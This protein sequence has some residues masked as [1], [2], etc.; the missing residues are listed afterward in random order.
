MKD[1]VIPGHEVSITVVEAG[2]KWK[3]QYKPGDRFIV[4]ADV[5]Y[6]GVNLA[7]GYALPGGMQQ[8]GIIGEPVLNGDEG[9]YLIPVKPNTGY[10]E[11]ALVE[12]WT[13][14]VAAYR[15]HP[16]R[17]VKPDGIMLIVGIE[18]GNYEIDG[19]LCANGAPKKIILPAFLKS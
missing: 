7:Y 5:Y 13:C 6:K 8:Y 18:E 15:I 17:A 12:P 2:D 10:A 14:V 9:S 1:P 4:Q 11:A 16:R 19:G 3:E